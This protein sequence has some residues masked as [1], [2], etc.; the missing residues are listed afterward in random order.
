M[1]MG[2]LSVPLARARSKIKGNGTIK[3]YNQ[4]VAIL[5]AFDM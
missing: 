1:S 3:T 5:T 2:D 4:D